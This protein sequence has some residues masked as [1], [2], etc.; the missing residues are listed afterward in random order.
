VHKKAGNILLSDGSVQQL[1]ITGLR[2]AIEN[3]GLATNRLQMPV[4]EP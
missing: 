1:S 4:L 3:T 2:A